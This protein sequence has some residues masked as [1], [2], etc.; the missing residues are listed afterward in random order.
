M[1]LREAIGD[2]PCPTRRSWRRGRVACRRHAGRGSRL[3]RRVLPARHRLQ[4][5]HPSYGYR[6]AWSVGFDGPACD[7]RVGGA[8]PTPRPVPGISRAYTTA[9]PILFEGFFQRSGIATT[10]RC[11]A[12]PPARLRLARDEL[13]RDTAPLHSRR[14][15]RRAPGG[16]RGAGAEIVFPP[17]GARGG[18]SHTA[19][20]GRPRW[21]SSCRGDARRSAGSPMG[22]RFGGRLRAGPHQPVASARWASASR[23]PSP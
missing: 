8:A 9:A 13:A 10:P 17:D 20:I 19:P 21:C 5:R 15:R 11:R 6:D 23:N 3:R 2:R 12:R 7:R 16:G 1:T 22:A 18:N 14:T 4:D